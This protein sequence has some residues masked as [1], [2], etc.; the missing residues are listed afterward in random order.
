MYVPLELVVLFQNNG[1]SLFTMID[2]NNAIKQEGSRHNM[3]WYISR[4]YIQKVALGSVNKYM[5]TFKSIKICQDY[6][7]RHT[8]ENQTLLF[9]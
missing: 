1:T 2:F 4:G 3:Y 7:L 9:I 5:L 6:I 8:L